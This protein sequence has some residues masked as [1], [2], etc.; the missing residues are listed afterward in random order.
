MATKPPRKARPDSIEALA[1][2]IQEEFSTTR[3]EA[4][5]RFDDVVQRVEDLDLRIDGIERKFDALEQAVLNLRDDLREAQEFAVPLH[6][7]GRRLT[8]VERHLGI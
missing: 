3:T 7:H 4:N 1:R 8:R 5:E 2:L 6:D